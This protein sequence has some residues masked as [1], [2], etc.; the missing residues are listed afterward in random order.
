M[1]FSKSG[2]REGRHAPPAGSVGH[3]AGVTAVPMWRPAVKLA[4]RARPIVGLLRAGGDGRLAILA[5]LLAAAGAVPLAAVYVTRE[6]VDG[7]VAAAAVRGAWAAVRPVLLWAGA[8]AALLLASHLLGALAGW[9]RA[10]HVE[11]LQDHVTGR[12]HEQSARL[13]LQFY[14]SAD[15]Y[16]GLHRARTEA[17]YRP[18]ALV[19]TCCGLFQSVITLAG[20]AV[21]LAG[22]GPWLPAALVASALPALYVAARCGV[23]EQQLR[24]ARTADERRGWYFDAVLTSAPHAPELRLFDLGGRFQA[25]HAGLRR[26]LAAERLALARQRGAAEVGAAMLGLLAMGAALAWI[27]WQ[28]VAGAVTLGSLA[29]FYT[30]FSQGHSTMKGLLGGVGSLYANSVFLENLSE[31]LALEP[32]LRDPASPAPV[33]VRTGRGAAVRFRGVTFRYPQSGRPAL[34]QFDLELS[35]G[36]IAAV[37]GP[38]GSG[39]STLVK[40]LCRLYDP[41]QGAIEIDGVDLRRYRLA[42]LRRLVSALFQEPVRYADTAS[43]NIAIACGGA[44]LPVDVADALRSAGAWDLV[45]ALPAG[46]ETILGRQF[47]DGVELSAG[48]WQRIALARALVRP[49]PILALDEPTSA[50]DPWA[51]ADWFRRFREAAGGRTAIV[52]THRLSTAMQADVIHVM[53]DGRVVESGPHALLLARGGAYARSWTAAA[54]SGAPAVPAFAGGRL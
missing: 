19:E 28:A 12:V 54:D 14:E 51:E 50:L 48:E 22:F 38:N 44:A 20:L 26:R 30:A 37:V 46:T 4:V 13:D 10:A 3:P 9:L 53:R 42:D 41:Q 1:G 17:Q 29:A 36:Q 2:R 25:A 27:G 32:Q 8:A 24:R 18:A 52:I 21:V 15:F 47:A 5:V 16:D 7:L 6:V 23:R 39:K 11:R 45:R 40:L 35:P 33:P 34:S 31:F 43:D 49:G